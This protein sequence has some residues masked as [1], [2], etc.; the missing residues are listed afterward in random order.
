VPVF[1]YGCSVCDYTVDVRH[2]VHGHGPSTCPVCGGSMRKLL[3]TPTIVFKGSG[4]ASKEGRS[5]G[6]GRST[7]GSSSAGSSDS[8]S[9]ER[10]SSERGSSEAGSKGGSEGAAAPAPAT[11][12]SSG[13][14][15]GS[16]SGD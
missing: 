14:A 12:S 16:S 6:S 2:G 10:G 3:S 8:G 5:G 4:W 9:S 1:E 15:A 13:S 7:S 11:G